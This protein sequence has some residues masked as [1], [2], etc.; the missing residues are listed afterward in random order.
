ML[1][2]YQ[3]AVYD[4]IVNSLK[5]NKRV[6]SVLPCGAGKSYIFAEMAR[7]CKGETLILTHRKELLEQH[8]KL[9]RGISNARV[10]MILTEANRL[11]QYPKPSLLITDEA[12]LSKANSWQKVIEYYDT[13]T[14]GFT[15]TPVRLD[16][17]PLGDIY[18][19][20]VQGVSAKWLIENHYLA[21]FEYYAPFEVSA[22]NVTVNAGDYVVKELEELMTDRAIYSDVIESYKK[23]AN[24]QKTIA[25]CVSIKHAEET[26]KM[27]RKNG[28]SAE[29]LSS[30]TPQKERERVMNDFRTGKITVLCNVGIISEGVS[31]DDLMCCMLLR[32]TQSHALYWQQALRCCRYLPNKTALIIDC[33]GNYTRN[34]LPDSDI[35]WSLT[36]APKKGQRINSEG[37]F[38]IRTCP[39]CFKVFQIAPICPYC[40][41]VYPVSERELKAKEEIELKRITEEEARLAEIARKKARQAQGMARTFPE[42]VEIGK[43]RNYKNPAAWAAMVLRGRR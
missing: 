32:P 8:S 41:T 4:S 1:R 38:T 18:N 14:V 22:E 36:H 21:P 39:N 33:V 2:E 11:G 34:P 26:A 19:S 16:N 29:S 13:Y 10:S 12:H 28:Y 40:G 15:A 7:N 9:L 37:D 35:N 5:A 31:I 20:L 25:Y 24:G 30:H 17:K 3:Q 43:S 6:L 27:F 23:L 42:L